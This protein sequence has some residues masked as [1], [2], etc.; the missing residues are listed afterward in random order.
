MK[1][2]AAGLVF[3]TLVFLNQTGALYPDWTDLVKADVKRRL[4]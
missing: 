1:A 3:V 4:A 2:L